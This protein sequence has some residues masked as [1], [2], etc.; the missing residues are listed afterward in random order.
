MYVLMHYTKVDMY[1]V[2]STHIHF[3]SKWN[4]WKQNFIPEFYITLFE[5]NADVANFE[6]DPRSIM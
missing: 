4:V 5:K 1:Y 6:F 3:I 2:G